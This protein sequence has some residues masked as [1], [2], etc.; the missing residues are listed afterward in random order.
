M[1][2]KTKFL[3][4]ITDFYIKSRDFN[5]KPVIDLTLSITKS[6][7]VIEKLIR[8]DLA[9]INYGDR[10][11]NSH[12]L[13]FEPES[14]SAQLKKLKKI[15]LTYACLYPSKK[16]LSIVVD[17]SRY[18]GKPFALMMALG[19]P[20]F[21]FKVFDLSILEHYRND[22]RYSFDCDDIHGSLSI[23]SAFSENGTVYKRDSVF[24]QTFGFAYTKTFTKRAVAV[25]VRYLANLSPEHQQLWFNK[26]LKGKFLLHPDYHA[27]SMGNWDINESI[28]NAFIEELHHINAMAVLMGKPK[29]FKEEFSR[30]T[31]P[32]GFSFLIRPTLKEFNDFTSLLDKLMS[33][34]L[35]NDFF[36]SDLSLE[37]EEKMKNGR[38]KVI[39]KGTIT[40]LE[41]WLKRVRFLDPE[42]KNKM[43]ETFRKVRKLRQPHAHAIHDDVFDQKYFKQQRKLMI[44]AYGAIRTLRLIFANH[45]RIKGYDKVPDWLY[46]G[47]ISIY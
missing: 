18:L 1:E 16:H 10:H 6:L 27:A 29:L 32:R 14:I 24:I 30:E 13:A 40:L 8:E 22:P 47:E 34:N 38:V 39:Q 42:P 19:E 7:P 41:E 4:E 12:I 35:N 17:R 26:K 21:A 5:G 33:E 9:S 45:P 43:F 28:F 2:I 3:K 36:K 31:K 37:I 11:P 46:K 23:K 44:D 25:Y 20:Q 15:D